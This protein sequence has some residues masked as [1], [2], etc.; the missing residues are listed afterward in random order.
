[1][2]KL[3]WCSLPQGP[4]IRPGNTV[5]IVADKQAFPQL[6]RATRWRQAPMSQLEQVTWLSN[7][8]IKT[9]AELG[10]LVSKPNQSI[11]PAS[12]SQGAT[13]SH[14]LMHE[15]LN[16]DFI[17]LNKCKALKLLFH[18]EKSTWESSLCHAFSFCLSQINKFGTIIA[19][20]LMCKKLMKCQ[21]LT[22]S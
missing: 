1:M 3:T 20:F 18:E 12:A 5:A 16:R 13:N 6:P 11:S 10:S 8:S 7:F 22:V 17:L 15:N 21:S 19:V 4:K 9:H 14:V 2:T